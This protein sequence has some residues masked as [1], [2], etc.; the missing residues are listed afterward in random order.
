MRIKT[1]VNRA[2]IRV[3]ADHFNETIAVYTL[4]HNASDA[5][6]GSQH[7]LEGIVNPDKQ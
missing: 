1:L 7:F 4:T 6:Q 5:E 3:I 2:S